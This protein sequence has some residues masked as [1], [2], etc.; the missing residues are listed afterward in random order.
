MTTAHY[1]NIITPPWAYQ[2][3]RRRLRWRRWPDD[4]DGG[5]DDHCE[6]REP[7]RGGSFYIYRIRVGVN[8][9]RR[10]RRVF[11]ARTRYATSAAAVIV[12]EKPHIRGLA[13]VRFIFC[14]I[15]VII[16][17]CSDWLW[18]RTAAGAAAV[19]SIGCTVIIFA[20]AVRNNIII[21]YNVVR[22]GSAAVTFIIIIIIIVYYA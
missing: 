19:I 18:T 2:S 16:I 14:Y 15:T 21:F 6:S 3:R 12:T 1:R 13:S 9:A 10:S 8:R 4:D 7:P 17:V 5:D 11:R 22:R 20:A